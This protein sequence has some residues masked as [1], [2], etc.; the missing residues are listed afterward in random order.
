MSVVAPQ[1]KDPE[2]E[3][4]EL[5]KILRQVGEDVRKSVT[6]PG[7]TGLTYAEFKASRRKKK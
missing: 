3:A 6:Q 5:Q 7:K 2:A 4:V 1:I